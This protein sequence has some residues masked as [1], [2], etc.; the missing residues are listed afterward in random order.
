[1]KR[2]LFALVAL[3]FACSSHAEIKS[4]EKRVAYS[5]TVHKRLAARDLQSLDNEA[6]AFQK[7]QD[8]TADGRWKLTLFFRSVSVVMAQLVQ[9]DAKWPSFEKRLL[10]FAERETRSQHAWLIYAE[11]LNAKA[12]HVRGRGFSGTTTAEGR[13]QYRQIMSQ[14]RDALDSHKPQLSPNPH[15]YA[16]RIQLGS[17]LGESTENLMALFKEGIA[18]EPTYYPTYYSAL[19][20]LTPRWGGSER[21]M[22]AF[23]DSTRGIAPEGTSLYARLFLFLHEE[24]EDGIRDLDGVDWKLMEASMLAILKRYPDD[25]NSQGFLMMACMKGDMALVRRVVNEVKEPASPERLGRN[26]EL[27]EM[28]RDVAR[29]KMEGFI[30]NDPK[31]GKQVFMK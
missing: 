7:S 10:A 28:C 9:D 29:G 4:Y 14:A 11:A 23:I 26:L 20:S 3:L 22:L 5:K 12:W 21:K 13:A 15:W 19:F 17:Y 18:K 1:M 2:W 6:A 30:M 31:T 8:R 16:Q 25:W 27:F 24:S